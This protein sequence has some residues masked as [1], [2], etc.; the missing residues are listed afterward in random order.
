MLN[1]I[2]QE[3][4]IFSIKL[5][6][7]ES[8]IGHACGFISCNFEV[9]TGKTPA[10]CLEASAFRK[11]PG[12]RCNSH[13]SGAP[14]GFCHFRSSCAIRL[15]QGEAHGIFPINESVAYFGSVE[16]SSRIA[17]VSRHTVHDLPER[18]T[19]KYVYGKVGGQEAGQRSFILFTRATERL[20]RKAVYI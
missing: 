15:R 17:R 12:R 20:K 3:G 10:L 6:Q 4:G 18:I 14:C 5:R 9:I 8:A 11:P 7:H 2:L 1:V 13:S 19:H 16:G